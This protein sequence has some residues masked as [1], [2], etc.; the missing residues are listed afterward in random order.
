MDSHC[1]K[2]LLWLICRKA[3]E[4]LCLL[5]LAFAFCVSMSADH[6]SHFQQ[7]SHINC[8]FPGQEQGF[9]GADTGGG[10]ELQCRGFA[11]LVSV[12]GSNTGTG[13]LSVEHREFLFLIADFGHNFRLIQVSP[14]RVRTTG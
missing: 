14:N 4:C 7:H 8:R 10:G 1:G 13:F 3:Q 12:D 2:R 11:D 9:V 6:L 5:V